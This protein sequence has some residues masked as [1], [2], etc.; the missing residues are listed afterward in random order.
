MQDEN[1]TLKYEQ[2]DY[3]HDIS[4]TITASS[5]AS[6]QIKSSNSKHS[7]RLDDSKTSALKD[8]LLIGE[9]KKRSDMQNYSKKGSS[10]QYFIRGMY[11][12]QQNESNTEDIDKIADSHKNHHKIPATYSNKSYPDDT[13][14]TKENVAKG[15]SKNVVSTKSLKGY[16][17]R[18]NGTP[19]TP[20]LNNMYSTTLENTSNKTYTMEHDKNQKAH[21]S[22]DLFQ[23]P[24]KIVSSQ[25]ELGM[26]NRVRD[27]EKWWNT[28]V[29][30]ERVREPKQQNINS[31]YPE[32]PKIV[33]TA[34]N[35]SDESILSDEDE[36]LP[37]SSSKLHMV[38]VLPPQDFIDKLKDKKKENTA[39][40]SIN[41]LADE[42]MDKKALDLMKLFMDHT[43]DFELDEEEITDLK[44]RAKDIEGQMYKRTLKESGN[45]FENRKPRL[46]RIILNKIKEAEEISKL[47]T[48][49]KHGSLQNYLKNSNIKDGNGGIQTE[50]NE[51]NQIE[52]RSGSFQIMN[53]S[54][55][56]LQPRFS[57]LVFGLDK[58]RSFPRKSSSNFNTN[59]FSPSART[60]D[61]GFASIFSRPLPHQSN[62][63]SKF[64]KP[65][66]KAGPP[67]LTSIPPTSFTCTDGANSE[68]KRTAGYYADPETNCQVC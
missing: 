25:N 47:K 62:H 67:I 7:F 49:N 43:D 3:R 52:E 22:S 68:V 54:E 63:F 38:R 8:K 6:I 30:S 14:F 20:T 26:N 58:E 23:H 18:N 45:Q 53:S 19:L 39:L 32:T 56:T 31:Q 44:E 60:V 9:S 65:H 48:E 13:F 33:N 24:K 64:R 41:G 1:G 37:V 51:Y 40:S 21:S 17:V 59:S 12:K 35:K 11:K 5:P 27:R 66:H 15:T 16:E 2:K 28:K 55:Q 50:T 29:G 34:R 42:K 10:N 36:F 57:S 46:S 61:D 4:T